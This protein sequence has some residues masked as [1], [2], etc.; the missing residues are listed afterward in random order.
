MADP[1][2]LLMIGS[3]AVSAIGGA[4][5][6]SHE[7]KQA[8]TRAKIG[9]MQ[10]DQIEAG[11]RNELA[12]TLNNIRAIR[13]TTGVGADSP[14]TRAIEGKNTVISD[15]NR[16]RDMANRRIQATEDENAGRYKRFSAGMA[17][18]GGGAKG[19]TQYFGS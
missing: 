6:L 2:T 7:A 15:R 1:I 11:Y 4:V 18:L 17:L 5:G 14:T 3:T 12:T 10:A 19:L 9:R 8:E 16:T 13:A